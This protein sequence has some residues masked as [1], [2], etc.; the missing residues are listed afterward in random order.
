M[1]GRMRV[2]SFCLLLSVALGCSRESA[3]AGQIKVKNDSRDREYNIISVSGGGASASL[4]PGQSL[5]LSKGTR[6][7]SVERRYEKFTRYYSVSCPPLKGDGIVVKLIDI[8][9]NRIRG[10]CQTTSASTR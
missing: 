9:V 7:F 5:L 10:G 2:A 8:H 3:P 4:K 1:R 6:S